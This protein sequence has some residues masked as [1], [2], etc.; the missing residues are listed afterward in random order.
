MMS[1]KKRDGIPS[2]FDLFLPYSKYML[3]KQA[4][5][6]NT[7]PAAEAHKDWLAARLNE[8]NDVGV[9]ANRRHCHYDKK[10][11]DCFKWGKEGLGNAK[12]RRHGGDER[13][14]NEKQN[15]KRE[16]L[17]HIDGCTTCPASP[18]VYEQM[19]EQA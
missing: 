11:A 8:F 1:N 10:L 16:N 9:K 15:K 17:F 2:L 14:G 12:R 13:C 7:D 4:D 6:R 19:R 5:S 18:Y 3:H